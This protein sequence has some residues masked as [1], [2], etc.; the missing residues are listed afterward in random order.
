VSHGKGPSAAPRS[1]ERG[2]AL[3]Q[4]D[5]LDEGGDP[6]FDRLTRLTCRVFGAPLALVGLR[7]GNGHVLTSHHGL[8]PPAATAD[9]PPLDLSFCQAVVA[10]HAGYLVEDTQASAEWADHAGIRRL[11]VGSFAGVPLLTPAGQVFGS[12]CVMQAAARRWTADDLSILRDLAAHAVEALNLRLAGRTEI[13][14]A[15]GIGQLAGGIAHEFNNL[16]TTVGGHAT[17]L[18]EETGLSPRGRDSV[19]QIQRATERAVGLIRQ[20]LLLKLQNGDHADGDAGAGPGVRTERAP[21]H[22]EPSDV[23]GMPHETI[24]LVEDEEQVRELARR[25]LQRAGYTVLVAPD[26]EAASAIADRHPGHI[27]LLLTDVGLPSANGRELAAR[28]SIHRPAVKVLYVSGTSDGSIA[29]HLLLQPGTDFLEKPFSLDRLLHK[30]RQV[31][32]TADRMC[33]R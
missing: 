32:R 8:T 26:A 27:H 25:V 7:E 10:S 9:D 29:R 21:R 13:E 2:N 6:F 5:L 11:G 31:L 17:L 4:A 28:L 15:E 30:V 12:L 22:E 3:R 18:L 23:S 16:L 19:G 33:Q 1:P 20:L 24:L 14:R